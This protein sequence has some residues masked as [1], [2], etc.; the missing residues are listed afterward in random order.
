M[1]RKQ[2][3]AERKSRK[4]ALNKKLATDVVLRTWNYEEGNKA[5][6]TIAAYNGETGEYDPLV[7]V[8]SI[9]CL[10]GTTQQITI[11]RKNAEKH[12]LLIVEE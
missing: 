10:E 11:N 6:Q 1:Q 8:E 9:T 12:R 2:L 3:F 4:M 5:G 7:H